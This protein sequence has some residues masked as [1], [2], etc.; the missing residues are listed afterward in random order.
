MAARRAAVDERF[1][2]LEARVTSVEAGLQRVKRDLGE[3]RKSCH[4]V[5]EGFDKVESVWAEHAPSQLWRE[6]RLA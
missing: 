2:A 4:V 6:L 5:L 1:A 3:V